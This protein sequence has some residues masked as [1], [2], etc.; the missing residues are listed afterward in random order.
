MKNLP[1]ALQTLI[2]A[3]EFHP[4]VAVT[5]VLRDNATTLRIANRA[6]TLGGNPFTGDL[7]DLPKIS[8]SSGSGI[9]HTVISVS[10]ADNTF[11]AYELDDDYD[12]ARCTVE[13]Y[14][15]TDSTYTVFEGP[16][17]NFSG[18]VSE[19]VL[20]KDRIQ[21]TVMSDSRLTSGTIGRTITNNCLHE[22]RSSNC[23]YTHSAVV[24]TAGTVSTIEIKN[25]AV[26]GQDGIAMRPINLGT[27]GAA[28]N[29]VGVSV[30]C[31]TGSRCLYHSNKP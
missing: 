11:S 23:G 24:K 10:N 18:V 3:D 6:V 30:G 25:T 13:S 29:A 22:F 27:P 16:V 21:L 15:A 8:V 12:G 31:P 1:A 17:L 19:P 26:A 20:Y 9:D 28:Q 4:V 2:D 5:I 14:F 7:I